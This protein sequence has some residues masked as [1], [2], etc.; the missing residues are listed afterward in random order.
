EVI[1]AALIIKEEEGLVAPDRTAQGATELVVGSWRFAG[2]KDVAGAQRRVA[3]ELESAAVEAVGARPHRHIGD[4]AAGAAELRIVVAGR[5]I[6]GLDDFG[7]QDDSGQAVLEVIVNTFELVIVHVPA[8]AVD[9][10]GK[11]VLR[12]VKLRMW[13]KRAA[14]AGHQR[15]QALV[16]A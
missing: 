13:T 7:R 14:H 5:D 16:V 1:A 8:L 6:H 12:V 10:G 2:G 11:M 3:V 9:A 15:Q 4:G